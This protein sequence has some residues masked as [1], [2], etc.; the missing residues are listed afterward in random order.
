MSNQKKRTYRIFYKQV[1]S[2]FTDKASEHYELK[3]R[4][5]TEAHT[6]AEAYG[7]KT[8]Q[9]VVMIAEVG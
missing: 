8:R 1:G 3:F 2:P 5:F 6:H 9:R 7:K 4:N